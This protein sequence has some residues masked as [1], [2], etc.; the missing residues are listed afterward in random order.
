MSAAH[1][2]VLVVGAGSIGER[3][4]RCFQKTGRTQVSFLEL[5]PELRDEIAA[6]YPEAQICANW[7]EALQGDYDVVVIATPAPLHVRQ[8]REMLTAG[9]NVLIE[10]PLSVT[11]EGVTELQETAR[12]SGKVVGVAY[13]Y[14]AN[15][16]LTQMRAALLSGKYGK[17]VELVAVCGQNFP[18]YRPAYRSTYYA[19]H[20]SGG[21]AIQDALTHIVNAGQWLVGPVT[22]V[23]ADAAH[24]LLDGV[25]V[26]DTV[27]VLARHENRILASY[28]LNQH[29]APNEV[30]ITVICERGTLRFENHHLRWRLLET[31]ETP[32]QDSEPATL[33]RDELFILQAHAFLDAVEGRAEV[34]CSLDEGIQSLLVNRALLTSVAEG[35]W[36]DIGGE[37]RC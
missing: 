7:E 28:T 20:E 23:V 17:P 33:E 14:R 26:E 36:Q 2:H 31:P 13:V 29:Q 24:Q 19:S 22:R 34:L 21:G 12:N 6:R 4:L 37:A 35:N 10:K 9:K 16:V 5:R 11:L 15:P 30:T 32:W 27:H 25:D 1:H 8:A 18:T 3:H